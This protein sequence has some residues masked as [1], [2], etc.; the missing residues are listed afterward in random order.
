MADDFDKNI[1]DPSEH[2]EGSDKQDKDIL[3]W[4][5]DNLHHLAEDV[6]HEHKDKLQNALQ[7]LKD[8]LSSQEEKVQEDTIN[9]LSQ[10]RSSI[11]KLDGNV[12]EPRVDVAPEVM[13][14]Q[15]HFD[16]S[17][18]AKKGIE[19]SYENIN[20]MI[21]EAPNDTNPIAAVIGRLMGKILKTEKT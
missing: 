20:T 18:Q 19:Q 13:S 7:S 1:V 16:R 14:S 15:S 8:W 11:E 3:Q 4:F 21:Q 2:K 9:E 5:K 10:L 12:K 6:Y 17:E